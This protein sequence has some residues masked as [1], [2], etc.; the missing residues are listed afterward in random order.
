ME[1]YIPKSPARIAQRNPINTVRQNK[2]QQL[3]FTDNRP[4]AVSQRKTLQNMGQQKPVQMKKTETDMVEGDLLN[5]STMRRRFFTLTTRN[6]L[7]T[8]T[9]EAI[10]NEQV[11]IDYQK[12]GGSTITQGNIKTWLNGENEKIYVWK[13]GQLTGGHN[14]GG[15]NKVCHPNLLGGNPD[16]DYAGTI[17]PGTNHWHVTRDS[18]HFQPESNDTMRQN[19]ADHMNTLLKRNSNPLVLPH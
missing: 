9:T 13:E 14:P 2:K 10:E 12:L 8:V 15:T 19:I 11:P 3:S 16:V 5:S 17:V 1:T 4:V 18:G 7:R 6:A